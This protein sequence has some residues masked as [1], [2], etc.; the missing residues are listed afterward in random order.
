MEKTLMTQDFDFVVIGAGSGGLTAASFATQLGARVALIEKNRIGG[1]CTW[2]GC[3]PSKALLKVAKVAH[4]ARSAADFG[5]EV[6]SHSVDM[7]TVRNYVRH[8]IASVYQ[9]ETPEKLSE[10]G[11]VV[12]KGAARFL[13]THTIQVG[14]EKITGKKFLIST[15][16]RPFIPPIPGLPDVPYFTH[17]NFFENDKLLER[18]IILGAGPIGVEMAQA[19]QRLGSNVTVVDKALL[20]RQDRE[21]AN[22]ILKVF[23]REGVHFVQGLATAVELVSNKIVVEVNEHKIS[24][25]MLLVATGRKPNVSGMSLRNLGVNYDEK[26]IEV[27]DSLRTSV[28]HIYAAGDVIGGQQF[29]HLA[30]YQGF[31]AARNALLPGND[32]NNHKAVPYTIFTDPEVAQ[33]GSTEMEARERFGDSIRVAHRSLLRSDR[34]VCDNSLDGFIKIIHK[35]DGSVLGATIVSDRAGETIMEFVLAIEYKLKL[36]D[37]AEAIH[38]YPSYTMDAMRLA[39]DFTIGKFTDG[40]SGAVARQL[41]KLA[42]G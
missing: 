19:Y 37:L 40:L 42:M 13:D 15:G 18:L 31:Q 9:Y 27:N 28:N 35:A 1:D 22:V 26:G 17:E 10:E 21:A 20:P 25:D 23:S 41:A 8:A 32:R 16:A 2:T 30:A 38:V 4:N 33:V 39:A 29:T 6:T 5:I 36:Q 7:A 12:F 34:A 11:V 24:G 3:V 14:E